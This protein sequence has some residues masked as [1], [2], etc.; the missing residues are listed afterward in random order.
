MRT[1]APSARPRVHV[2][3]SFLVFFFYVGAWGL[4]EFVVV[5]WGGDGSGGWLLSSWTVRRLRP[6]HLCAG[7]SRLGTLLSVLLLGCERALTHL[8]RAVAL[9]GVPICCFCAFLTLFL[10]ASGGFFVSAGMGPELIRSRH[11]GF[12][13][14]IWSLGIVGLELAD[15]E[16]PHTAGGPTLSAPATGSPAFCAALAAC[17]VTVLP[18]AFFFQLSAVSH[19]ATGRRATCLEAALR[20]HFF[21]LFPESPKA[22]SARQ[23]NTTVTGS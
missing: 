4:L 13:A 9:S 19:A 12:N 7:V 6:P 8:F 17:L 5:G 11:W 14:G 1:S 15:Y 3:S 10:C 16:P 23:N 20:R 21:F 22:L 2:L 18:L